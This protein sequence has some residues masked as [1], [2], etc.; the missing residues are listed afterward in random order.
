MILTF[1]CCSVISIQRARNLVLFINRISGFD[2]LTLLSK[3]GRQQERGENMLQD[4]FNF[5]INQFGVNVKLKRIVDG[6]ENDY[7][8]EH[9]AIISNYKPSYSMPDFDDKKIHCQFKIKRG[10]IIE[11]DNVNYL[12]ISDVQSKRSYEYK[13]IMRPMTNVFEFTYWTEGV[14]VDYDILGNPIYDPEPEEVTEEFPCIAYQE[15]SAS[16]EGDRVRLP[17]ERIIVI[18]PDNKATEQVEL[19]SK[20]Q[21]NGTSY[22]VDNINLFQKGLRIFTMELNI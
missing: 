3:K 10:D 14:I 1:L 5:L 22:Q 4:D 16:I 6:T 9:K 11:Y 21:M 8:K 18:L 19:N 20:H 17:E 15:G 7:I 13:A 12:I 2:F